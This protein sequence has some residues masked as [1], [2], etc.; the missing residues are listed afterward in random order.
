MSLNVCPVAV[1]HAPVERVWSFLS[2]PA[3]FALWWEAQTQTITPEGPARPG[4]IIHAKLIGYGGQRDMYVRVE[5]VEEE[6]RLLHLK[7]SLPFGI[8]VYNHITCTA[9][10]RSSCQVSFG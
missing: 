7:T 6:K 3:N 4:Q 8:T 2:V 10:D 5:G 1:V 9:M